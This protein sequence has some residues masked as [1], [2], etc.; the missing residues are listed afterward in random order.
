MR[1]R[2]SQE[3]RQWGQWRS[4]EREARSQVRALARVALGAR[5]GESGEARQCAAFGTAWLVRW[6]SA[7]TV[8]L[9]AYLARLEMELVDER[10]PHRLADAPQSQRVKHSVSVLYRRALAHVALALVAAA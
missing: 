1:R 2:G 10:H 6:L 4:W 9:V 7:R 3:V 8:V 5:E